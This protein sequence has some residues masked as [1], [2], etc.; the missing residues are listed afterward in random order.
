MFTDYLLHAAVE[1]VVVLGQSGPRESGIGER[2]VAHV[3]LVVL[4]VVAGV[5]RVH[6]AG[7][8][9]RQQRG[10]A[11]LGRLFE[12]LQ[13]AGSA[14]R[15]SQEL[16]LPGDPLLLLAPLALVLLWVRMKAPL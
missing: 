3:V 5:R 13:L 16:L 8:G 15:R 7:A 6:D 14:Q 9:R 1:Q 2:R 10:L 11:A 12:R 4:L